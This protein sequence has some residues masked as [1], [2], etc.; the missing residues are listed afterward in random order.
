VIKQKKA[1]QHEKQ[2]LELFSQNPVMPYSEIGIQVGITKERVRQ[3]LKANNKLK[4][5]VGMIIT[6]H[7]IVCNKVMT[8]TKTELS[9][10]TCS[11][12]CANIARIKSKKSAELVTLTCFRC[13]TI[14]TRKESEAKRSKKHYCSTACYSGKWKQNGKIEVKVLTE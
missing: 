4:P 8:G 7:C 2:V 3:I 14:F 12:K 5:R 6:K 10:K 1:K 9:R 13:G 11:D